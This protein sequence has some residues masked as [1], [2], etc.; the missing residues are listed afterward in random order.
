MLS[1][2]GAEEREQTICSGDGGCFLDARGGHSS[3]GQRPGDGGSD[4]GQWGR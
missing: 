2:L 3:P 1:A 4:S